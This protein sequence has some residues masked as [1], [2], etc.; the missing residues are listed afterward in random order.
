MSHSYGPLN[1][2][3]EYP[4]VYARDFD[5]QL[6]WWPDLARTC[7]GRLW[8]EPPSMGARQKATSDGRV[9]CLACSR[10]VAMISAVGWR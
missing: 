3:A 6:Q 9:F 10:T 4:T 8:V 7:H 5:R 2:V 1:G